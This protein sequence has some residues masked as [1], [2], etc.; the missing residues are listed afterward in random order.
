MMSEITEEFLIATAVAPRVSKVM[1]DANVKKVDHI[2]HGL[3]TICVITLQN[4]FTVTGES[5]CASPENYRKETGEKISYEN[6]YDKIWALMG[7]EL[8]NKLALMKGAGAPTGGILHLGSDV[9]TALGQKVVH[10]T[11]M[12]RLDYNVFRGWQLP[13]DENGEDEGYLVQYADGGSPNVAGFDGYVSWSPKDVFE[14]AYSTVAEVKATTHVERMQRELADLQIKITK[15][16]AFCGG[17][18]F[19]TLAPEDQQDMHNQ[20]AAMT[21]YSDTLERRLSR[22]LQ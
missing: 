21:L 1:V 18:V 13:A 5:A 6:A 9:H 15:L 7:Y 19:L 11:P 2:Y 20:L 10:F 17:E 14:R 8:K 16:T 4:G 22:A 12:T 3:L